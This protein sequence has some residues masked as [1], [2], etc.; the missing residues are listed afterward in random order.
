MAGG[1]Q[2]DGVEPIWETTRF[3]PRTPF[4]TTPT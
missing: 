3:E 2:R 4:T 1:R